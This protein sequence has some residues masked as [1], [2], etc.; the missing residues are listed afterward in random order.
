MKTISV[1]GLGNRGTEYMSFIKLFHAKKAK[2]VAI[3]DINPQALIDFKPKYNIDDDH[4]F[5]NTSDFFSKGVLSDGLIISTQDQSHFEICKKALEVG[6][7]KIMLEKPVSANISEC[8]EL[9]SLAKEKGADLIVCH[10]LRYS[11]FFIKIKDIISSG[12]IGDI[13]HIDHT[14]NV[15]YFHFA[16]SYVRGN[17]KI[18][19]TSTPALL[20]KCC[21]DIDLLYWFIGSKCDSVTS[22]GDLKYFKK[23]N[24]PVGAT[25][26]CLKGCIVKD[27]CPYD[28]EWTYLTAPFYKATFVKYNHRTMTGKC[29]ATKKDMYNCLNNT[30]YGKCVY[31]NDNDVCDYQVVNMHFENGVTANHILNAFSNKMHRSG[32]IMGT[33]GEIIYYDKDLKVNIFGK[34]EKV[35]HPAIPFIPGHG[36]GDLR[37]VKSFVDL[38]Y[39]DVKRKEDITTISETIESHRIVMAAEMSRHNNSNPVNPEKVFSK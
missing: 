30:S 22:Y 32:H 19:S 38:L 39:D 14:E 3:C 7:K 26:Y 37:I 21:H 23:D 15:G 5:S 17:W 4:S 29:N 6:Y 18:E 9:E 12:A 25:E 24:A 2:I 11:N 20:A 35:L 8:L 28:C 10:V 1:I 34:G 36:E 27:K 33:K 13:I 16:H 31:L